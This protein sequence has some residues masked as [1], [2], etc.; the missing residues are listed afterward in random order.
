MRKPSDL[1][2]AFR[3]CRKSFLAIGLFSCGINILMLVPAFYMLQVYDRVVTSGSGSTLLMLTLVMLF[4]L[5]G[6]GLLDWLRSVI[7]VKVSVKIGLLLNQRIFDGAFK[8]TLLDGKVQNHLQPMQDLTGLR[9]FL[10]GNGVTS[11]FDA[12]WVPIYLAVMFFIHPVFGWIGLFAA[13]IMVIFALLNEHFNKGVQLEASHHNAQAV[14]YTMASLRNAE[15]VQ[16]M[17]MLANI[18][19]RWQLY[20]SK[21]L[22][23]QDINGSRS[24]FFVSLSKTVRFILQSAI[25]GAGA[26]LVIQQEM[27]PGLMIG[28]SLLLGRALAPIDQLINTWKQFINA[29]NQYQRLNQLL[30]ELPV[31]AEKTPLPVP[32]G[33]ITVER[34]VVAAPGSKAPI[35]KGLN[36][37][38]KPGEILGLIGPSAA[39][40]STLARVLLGI[41]PASNGKVRLDGADIFLRPADELGRHIGYLPQDVEL[42]EGTIAENIARFNHVDA[43]AV[44]L[45]ARQAGVHDMIL[46]LPQGYDTQI[47]SGG[48]FLSGGQRQ[49]IGLARALYGQPTLVVLDEPNASLD[50]QGEA[51]LEKAIQILKANK[52][53]VIIISHRKHVFTCVDTLFVMNAGVISLG[54]PREQVLAKLNS[55]PM[56]TKTPAPS[57]PA[58]AAPVSAKINKAI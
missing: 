27:T 37:S 9:Q 43:E 34:L 18:R 38:L 47:G 55:V 40:K 35:L 13:V 20:A 2:L 45:A 16:A 4:L 19:R 41:W 14:N 51:A 1:I 6:M 42:F 32:E 57:G 8:Q 31:E 39:G 23:Y 58:P 24:A 26:L 11:F 10:S 36:F 52:T 7:L 3:Q 5:A 30:H 17:G 21:A 50:E 12:P 56:P 28:G 15:V 46:R 54:G 49:R 48:S 25:L 53:T 29:R 33:R 22:Y 44:H